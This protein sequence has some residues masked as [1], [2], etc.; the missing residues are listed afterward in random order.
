[1]AYNRCIGTRYCANNCPYKVR[2]FNWFQYSANDKFDYHMNNDYGRMVLN[3]DVVVR[4][5]G[6]MEKCSMC[7]HMIQKTKLDAKKAGRQVA[8]ED[9][10]TACSLAC[11]TGA[12]VFG[13]VMNKSHEVAELKD[14]ARAYHMLEQLNTQPS[15]VYHTKVRNK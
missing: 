9:A 11:D 1:M 6:V 12:M 5:R 8:D 7:I 4:S 13:D 15:V 10:Q 2:R 3:P 14:S